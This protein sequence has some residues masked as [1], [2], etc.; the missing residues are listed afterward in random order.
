MGYPLSR[1]QGW[2]DDIEA[3]PKWM[4]IFSS[5]PDGLLMPETVEVSGEV[6]SRQDSIWLR[7]GAVV[8]TLNEASIWRNLPPGSVVAAVGA[9]DDPF[10]G[11]LVFSEPI[12]DPD[13]GD[14]TPISYPSGG[15]FVL[16]AGELELRI[17]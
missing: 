14:P 8:L 3:T 9:F 10:A 7:T 2:M 15:T 17:D 4:A 1:R 11:E 5:D 12:R 13:T 16:P 6:Y